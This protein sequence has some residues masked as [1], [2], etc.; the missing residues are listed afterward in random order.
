MT[1]LL[2]RARGWFKEREKKAR[3]SD[4]TMVD[5]SARS[6]LSGSFTKSQ[7]EFA[8][9]LYGQMVRGSDNAFFSPFSIS[10]ALAMT[11]AGARGDTADEMA[12][13]L[14]IPSQDET[15]HEVFA[16]IIQRLNASGGKA[17]EMAVANS[18][19]GQVGA[20]V[21]KE[22]VER[23]ARDYGGAMNLVDFRCLTEAARVKINRWVEGKTNKK[24]RNLIPRGGVSAETRM[25][26]AN[27]AYFKG[28]WE[29]AFREEDTKDQPFY[30]EGGAD[31]DVPLMQLWS[32]GAN[33]KVRYMHASGFQAVDLDYRGGDL[34]MLVLLPNE[35]DGLG[36][37][38]RMLSGRL[39]D[40]CV[41]K[42]QT[43][44]VILSLPRFKMTRASDLKTHLSALGMP[45][46]FD[47]GRADF[48]GIDGHA[49]PHRD[50][51]YI[52]FVFHKAFV[53]VNEKGTEAAAATA[54]VLTKWSKS[55]FSWEKKIPEF[56][57]D[58]PFVFAIR[59]RKS[60]VILFLGRVTDPTLEN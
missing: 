22:F 25:V 29:L 40:K 60:G 41:A 7:N 54:V 2:E 15:V 55:L 6:K 47:P 12:Q 26:L 46:A 48:S 14:R 3:H 36:K 58:H 34:S 28:L 30:L 51:L 17:Y 37:L 38:E 18:L 32:R 8:F 27:A 35:K 43:R 10:V 50:S 39:I 9:D 13:T 21:K 33:P 44:E 57:A 16:E 24:I 42:L 4:L 45:I 5:R 59:D 31:V 20:P 56:R 23:I 11:F 52:E 1:G 49:P 53:E 19:W